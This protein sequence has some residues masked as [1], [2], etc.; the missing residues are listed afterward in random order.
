MPW[1]ISCTI[2]EFSCINFGR[3]KIKCCCHL[4]WEES[5]Q[6]MLDQLLAFET[7]LPGYADGYM[8]S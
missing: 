4:Q 2:C 1:L 5:V 6:L 7:E 3:N 8:L